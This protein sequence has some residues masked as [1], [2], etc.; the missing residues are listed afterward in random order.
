MQHVILFV[1]SS[2]MQHVILFVTTF[3]VRG[4][5]AFSTVYIYTQTSTKFYV[6]TKPKIQQNPPKKDQIKAC[7]SQAPRATP[8]TATAQ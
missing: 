6:G 8:P 1:T 3:L 5:Q 4:L 7:C 2:I